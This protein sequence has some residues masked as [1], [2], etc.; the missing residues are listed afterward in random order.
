MKHIIK[1]IHFTLRKALYRNKKSNLTYKDDWQATNYNRIA[2]INA[3]ASKMSY[4]SSYLE[5]G[6]QDNLLFDAVPILNKKGVDPERGGTHRMTSDEFFENNET[7]F[8]LIFI[9]GLH[10]IEQVS[11]DLENSVSKL[12]PGGFIVIHD[13]LPRNWTEQTPKPSNK[14]WLG[15]VWKL[16]DHI[17][18]YPDIYSFFV[19]NIDHGVGVLQVK[20]NSSLPRIDLDEL[21]KLNFK[22]FAALKNNLR[23]LTFKKFLS[24]INLL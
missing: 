20:V 15:D 17:K 8:D 18:N 3:L 5:I 22:D 14:V 1:R 6:C 24:E 19:V 11:K 4:N 13:L 7:Q 9:D 21:K 23:I 12:N 16:S 2:V 10:T